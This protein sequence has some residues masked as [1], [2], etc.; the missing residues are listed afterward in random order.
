MGCRSVVGPGA[1]LRFVLKDD[2]PMSNKSRDQKPSE[3][4]E[5]SPDI[6]FFWDPVCPFAWQT[7][8]WLRRVAQLRG[9]TVDWRFINLSI[10]NEERD[11][12]NEFPEGYRES[13]DRGR[14]ML[15]VAAAVRAVE[16]AAAMDRLYQAFG[17]SIWHREVDDGADFRADVA[18]FDHLTQ[19]LDRAGVDR[20]H[21]DAAT[22]PS[23]DAELRAETIEAVGRTGDDVGTPI[24]TF[25]PPE[26]PSIFGPVISSVPETD[27]EC[28]ALY[29][30][31]VTLCGFATFSEL[32]RSARPRLD[33]PV[34]T[35]RPG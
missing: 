25:G 11:Y 34:I 29:D 27:E 19:V 26:G 1:G 17:E 8:R 13:H 3:L 16:G 23:W 32:K 30:A 18:T 21:V 9:L 31:T 5:R 14:R 12:D 6:E 7:S 20:L 35:G 24:I 2:L 28:L 15:R 10:L 33:L 22:D 4:L